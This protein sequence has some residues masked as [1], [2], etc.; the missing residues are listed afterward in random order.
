[1]I[2]LEDDNNEV[3]E[4]TQTSA[5]LATPS[6]QSDDT[7]TP[8]V[9]PPP[10]SES[11]TGGQPCYGTF[12]NAPKER[13]RTPRRIFR[14]IIMSWGIWALTFCLIQSSVA[15]YRF[16]DRELV[17]GI[18]PT[19]AVSFLHVLFLCRI[20]RRSFMNAHRDTRDHLRAIT[21]E[22]PSLNA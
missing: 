8:P 19:R 7:Q 16:L 14:T 5:T 11:E 15:V 2:I 4:E 20:D 21:G 6:S 3:K 18:R 10:Y 13:T 1:M 9:L 22:Y 17:R 12:D